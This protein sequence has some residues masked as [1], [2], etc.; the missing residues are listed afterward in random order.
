MR[1]LVA[2]PGPEFSVHDVYTGWV[3]ALR[4]LGQQ[5]LEFNLS[6]RLT[7]YNSALIEIEPGKMRRALVGD[8][9]R[10][11]AMNG[12]YASLYKLRPEVLLVIS[13]FFVPIQ[14]LDMARAYGTKVVLVHTESPYQ[15]RQQLSL[16]PHVDL[17]LINDP[18]NIAKFRALGPTDYV[19]HAY[20]PG[21]HYPGKPRR[22]EL[23]CDFTFVG[24]GFRSR[25]EFFEAMDFTDIDVLFGG[26]WQALDDDSPLQ[27]HI[28]H[29]AD[30][31]LDNA[32]TA[33][34]YRGAKVGIN[35]YRVEAETD[36]LSE[37][38]AMGPREV[39]MAACG[40][41]FLRDPR[42]EG[43]ELLPMLPTFHSPTEASLQI[44][45]WLA[46]GKERHAAARAARIAVAN[47]T[48][49]NH[50]AA[51]LQRLDRQPVTV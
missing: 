20:R 12:L 37:G 31:C 22:P 7:F 46:R 1:I 49:T 25:I 9:G 32:D 28:G 27:T 11:L 40:L 39:E 48:F 44:R 50:A 19:P 13:G 41:F 42:S 34:V 14:L 4:E 6:A 2:H 3:E 45:E 51:L 38:V 36:E 10:E 30:L 29:E 47:R 43:D 35:L 21:I 16:A 23:E 24:T 33:E 18:I 8:Q 17:N 15:D 26:N 5:V